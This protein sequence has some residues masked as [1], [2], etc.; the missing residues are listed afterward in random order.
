MFSIQAIQLPVDGFDAL[1]HEALLEGRHMIERLEREW[2]ENRNRFNGE[3]EV[4]LG[5]F[6]DGKLIAVGGLHKDPFTELPGV[7][8][9]RRVYV[10][11]FLEGTRHR[12][13]IGLRAAATC[14]AQL[15]R[16]AITN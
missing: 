10:M 14:G 15:P 3:G 6:A 16:G 7:G 8:R 11:S 12:Q 9:L 4:L 5:V 1:A 2:A 13:G